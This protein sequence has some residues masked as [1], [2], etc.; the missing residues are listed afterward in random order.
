MNKISV[1]LPLHEL[2]DNVKKFL[3]EAL[4]SLKN[5]KTKIN[6]LVIVI[7]NNEEL[8]NYLEN[9]NLDF[10]VEEVNIKINEGSTS[11]Q[12]Q[13]N[14]GV[15][16]VKHEWVSI[17]EFDD[18]YSPNW[19]NNA[20]KYINYYSEVEMFNPIVVEFNKDDNFVRF[21]NEAF[22]ANQFSSTLGYM[23]EEVL[24]NYNLVS[25]NGSVFSKKLFIGLGGLKESMK[26]NFNYE[27]M[28]RVLH[29]GKKIMVV[30]KLGYKHINGIEGSHDLELSKT[31]T[32]KEVEFW[33]D[34]A[35][36][37]Y[38]W[39]YDRDITYTE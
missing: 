10:G 24:S 29:M 33:L 18:K 34:T 28:L 12:A 25:M 21:T 38:V 22:W 39:D 16:E 9:S 6:E 35:R 8:V 27:F 3:P 1:V 7:P 2:T 14:L 26:L 36:E 19:F 23:D 17:L 20:I 4:E 30:P 11:Y 37:E 32:S 13:V 31:I 5:Q 15:S